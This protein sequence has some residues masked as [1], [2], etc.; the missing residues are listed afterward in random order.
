MCF[1]G[2]M[3]QV[4]TE[5]YSVPVVLLM[6]LGSSAPQVHIAVFMCVTSLCLCVVLYS[7][8]T[9]CGTLLAISCVWYSTRLCRCVVLGWFVLVCV[10]HSCVSQPAN[11]S[12]VC[13]HTASCIRQRW[14]NTQ[15]Q[16]K[17]QHLQNWPILCT[18][19][20]VVQLLKYTQMHQFW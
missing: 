8:V 10:W 7:L 3:P 13:T 19:G 12:I 17:W 15:K 5:E 2:P 1:I 20:Y 6:H 4:S 18:K 9:V 14:K 16:R 11:G